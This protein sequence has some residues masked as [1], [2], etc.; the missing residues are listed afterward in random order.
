M[1][2]K[3][4]FDR[5]INYLRV[6]VTDHCNYKCF[7][8][9]TPD[10]SAG[11]LSDEFLSTTEICKIVRNFTELGVR[12]VRLTGG[13]PLLRKDIGKIIKSL[14]KLPKLANLSLSTNAHL[15]DKHAASFKRSG[16]DRVNISLDTLDHTRFKTITQGGDLDKVLSGIEAAIQSGLQPLKINMVVMRGENADEIENMLDYAIAKNIQL[17]FIETM[18]VGTAGA[19]STGKFFPAE[20]ILSRVQRHCKSSLVEI[21]AKQDS[22][23]ARIYQVKG[24]AVKVGVISAMS[25]HFCDT[26]NRVRLTAKGRLI[27]CLGQENSVSLRDALRSGKSDKQLKELITAAIALKPERH[28]FADNKFMINKMVNLG[29]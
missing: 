9:R 19:G 23:P 22:G 13:E 20:E 5:Q 29:G 10:D 26:C 24:T 12:K 16:L 6:S 27:L 18:P 21:Y 2:L 15:L 8:C 25:Q 11:S 4:L 17:R 14:G 3:D 28:E 7:Y 1:Q